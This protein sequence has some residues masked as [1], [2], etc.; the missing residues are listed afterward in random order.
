MGGTESAEYTQLL[1]ELQG[2]RWKRYVPNPYRWFLRHC[3]LG[4]TLDIGSG[5]GRGLSYLDGHGVGVE[6]NQ[7]SVE[8]SRQ[9]GFTTF[10]PDEFLTSE[11]A[12]PG[13]FDA[14]LSAHVIEHLTP[15]DA[16]EMLRTYLPYVRP[17][18]RVVLITPQERGFE[19]MPAHITFTDTE[20]LVA[21]CDEAGLLVE[22]TRSFPLPRW[23]G[24]RF[25][26]NEFV[27]EAT[28]PAGRGAHR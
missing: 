27:V 23:A 21:L 12:V 2:S 11:Y 22:R 28:V 20:H 9:R 26:Y 7:A 3:H 14:L 24:R 6:H 16:T 15:S 1:A 4:F 13:R 25:T 10:L 17:G 18:G 19:R 5:I 8:I